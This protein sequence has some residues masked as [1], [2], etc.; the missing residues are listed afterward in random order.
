MTPKLKA[1]DSK[2][3]EVCPWLMKLEFGTFAKMKIADL[4]K[5]VMITRHEKS[6]TGNFD[7]V[8]FVDGDYGNHLWESPCDLESLEVIGR[9]P[10]LSDVLYAVG[11]VES[12]QRMAIDDK[13]RFMNQVVGGTFGDC[14]GN[15]DLTKPFYQQSEDT[16]DF[17]HSLLVNK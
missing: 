15:Y 13:G 14:W 17:L 3:K 2:I 1:L 8:W 12:D 11:K 4:N 9:E 5:K 6:K 10:E 16:I 7:I